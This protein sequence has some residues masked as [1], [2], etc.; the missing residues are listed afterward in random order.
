LGENAFWNRNAKV[1]KLL[2]NQNKQIEHK[3]DRTINSRQQNACIFN[4]NKNSTIHVYGLARSENTLEK[5][6]ERKK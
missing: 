1:N 5:C 2:L 4:A 3:I 6:I